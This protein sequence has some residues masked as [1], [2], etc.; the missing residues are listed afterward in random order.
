MRVSLDVVSDAG[1]AIS[2]GATGHQLI[3]PLQFLTESLPP[4]DAFAWITVT[5][6][7]F[8]EQGRPLGLV[9][10]FVETL[11]DPAG[12]GGMAGALR[13]WGMP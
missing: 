3:L 11:V 2:L 7:P 13:L 1:L 10:L 4:D 8:D 12:G 6:A 5:N 9:E